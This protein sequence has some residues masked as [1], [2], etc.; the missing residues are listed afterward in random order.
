MIECRIL[1]V[2]GRKKTRIVRIQNGSDGLTDIVDLLVSNPQ[3]QQFLAS[4]T[5]SV[6][7]EAGSRIGKWIVSSIG[8]KMRESQL[9]GDDRVKDAN[10]VLN[11]LI[12]RK[13]SGMTLLAN[14]WIEFLTFMFPDREMTIDRLS[15]SECDYIAQRI[16]TGLEFEQLLLDTGYKPDKIRYMTHFSGLQSRALYY[17]D[18]T[19]SFE[20][21]Y[22]DNFLCARVIDIRASSPQDFVNSIPRVVSD[23]NG[24]PSSPAILRD[25]DIFGVV[26]SNDLSSSRLTRLRQTI[27]TVQDTN[28][29][30]PRLVLVTNQELSEFLACDTQEE[31]AERIK[32]KLQE[33]RLYRGVVE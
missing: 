4:L 28:P 17:F 22:F 10:K 24:D 15:E 21:E 19:A 6:T 31:R 3:I 13:T 2:S 7:K 12:T 16:L 8:A 23:I 27:R 18:I 9:L 5:V 1:S 14:Y 29:S 25:H 32:S 26:L 11:E 20:Q 33:F 30:V